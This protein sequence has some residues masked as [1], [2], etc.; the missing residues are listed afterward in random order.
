LKLNQRQKGIV[1]ALLAPLLYALKS[2]GIKFAP[3]AKVEFFVFF[4]FFFDF[5][6][7]TPFFLMYREKLRSKQLP[8]HFIRAIFVAM[9][10][11]CSVYG[12]RHLALVD[13]ILLEYTLPLFVPLIAWVWQGQKITAYS[14]F[15]LI[16]GFSALFFL[17][18]PKL[19]FLH[20]ASFASIGTGLMS[21]I[22]TVS[23]N[24]LSKT[25]HLLAILF[26]FNVFSGALTL[27]PCLY[28]WESM[29]S[30]YSF[31][32]WLPF[33]FISFFGVLFQF[34][35]IKAY[36]LLPAHVAGNFAYFGVLFSALF[37]WL[38]WRE[39]MSAMQIL[40]A[41]LLIGSGLLMIRENQRR[42]SLDKA[43][44]APKEE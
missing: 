31:S 24:K 8:L 13:A 37:G 9:S 32:F 4:R 36:S 14:C 5:L 15:I 16:L 17:L 28:T 12:I 40:G 2:V 30:T 44:L 43:S 33:V 42:T 19:D 23:I 18:K 1:F 34:A 38:I 29:P 6:L 27:I 21:A 11:C 20:L 41:V 39:A 3:P 26:Y 10:I 22:T 7:L 35:I 25:E